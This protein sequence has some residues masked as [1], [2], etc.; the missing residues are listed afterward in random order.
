LTSSLLA[1]GA[2]SASSRA[3]AMEI[4]TYSSG[5]EGCAIPLA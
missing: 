2:H 4:M 1:T 5:P 3:L